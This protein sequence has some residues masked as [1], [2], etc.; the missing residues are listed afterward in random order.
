MKNRFG[1][2]VCIVGCSLFVWL[3]AVS[4]PV[5]AS[6]CDGHPACVPVYTEYC[7]TESRDCLYPQTGTCTFQQCEMRPD[8][9]SIPQAGGGSCTCCWNDGC[10]LSCGGSTTG[11]GG[12][13]YSYSQSSYAPGSTPTPTPIQTG[14]VRARAA[15]V[16][17]GTT[18]CAD[19]QASTNY[20]PVGITLFSEGESKTTGSDGSYTS[21]TWAT[22][23]IGTKSFSDAPANPDY[24]LTLA[25]WDTTSPAAQG[26]GYSAT[27]ANGSTLTWQLGYTAGTGWWQAQ[28]GDVYAATQLRS[29]IPS[30]AVGGRYAVKSGNTGGTPGTLT[31]GTSYDF[32]NTSANGESYVSSTN[33]LVNETRASTD[34][35]AV[36]YHRFGSPAVADY[37]GDTTLPTTAG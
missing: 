13:S 12:G 6:V 5:V 7:W 14:I 21:S 24:V 27:L 35:Y 33:W 34:Y 3:F 11:G 29:Y 16:P 25:C 37:T 18:S 20:I 9:C 23:P 15:L 1:R 10:Y 28:G 36:M 4:S 19:V 22:S 2:I 26:S 32:D 17:I 30:A 8:I 31:Y